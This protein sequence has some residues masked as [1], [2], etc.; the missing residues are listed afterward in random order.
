[1][2]FVG[3][4][5]PLPAE[6]LLGA[7]PAV[8]AD[9]KDWSEIFREIRADRVVLLLGKVIFPSG[10]SFNFGNSGTNRGTGMTFAAPDTPRCSGC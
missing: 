10:R 9:R 6:Y 8:V 3:N 5:R 1:M 7:H 2:R 4:V